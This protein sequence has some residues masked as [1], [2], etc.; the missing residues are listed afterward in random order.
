[1]SFDYALFRDGT[2]KQLLAQFGKPMKVYRRVEGVYDPATGTAAVTESTLTMNG[3]VVDYTSRQLD[4][5]RVKAG[6]RRVL[7]DPSGQTKEVA[8][9]DEVIVD[10]VR[11]MIVAT[12]HV[13]PAGT[14]V[15]FDCTARR[16]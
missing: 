4:G 1:M 15:L 2:T 6:D 12:S 14:T 10:N 13:R 7:L 3:V 5:E 16:K 8:V 11:H 9:G